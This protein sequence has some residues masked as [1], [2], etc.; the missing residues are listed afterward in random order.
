MSET[1]ITAAFVERIQ[2][3][4]FDTLPKQAVAVAKQV[5]TDTL[6]VMLAGATRAPELAAILIPYVR[7]QGGEPQA[8]VVSGGFKTS[9]PNAA[10]VNGTLANVLEYDAAWSPPNHPAS[11]TVPAILAIAEGQRLSGAEVLEAVVAAFEVQA[12]VRLAGT[13]LSGRFHKPGTTGMFG[14]AAGA[15]KAFKLDPKQMAMALGLAGSK[16]GSLGSNSGTMTK[17]SHAG[18]SARMGV[19][20]ALLARMGWTASADVF[21]PKGYFDTFMKESRPEL[22]LKGFGS[23]FWM[24]KPGVGFKAYP[25]IYLI[26]RAIDAALALKREHAFKPDQIA[27]VE[28]VQP[29]LSS[30]DRATPRDGLDAKHSTQ[31]ST[32]IA[33]L[34]GAVTIDSYSAERMQAADVKALLPKVQYKADKSIAATLEDMHATVIVTLKDGKKLS[35]RQ[36]QLAGW[37]GNPL[38]PEQQRAKFLSCAQPLLEQSD[39]Q[40]MLDL[41]DRIETLSDISAL[42]D[43]ARCDK[44]SA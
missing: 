35:K 11:P 36:D 34:D 22:L 10:F 23:P 29:P 27:S 14:A 44:R 25:C 39:A 28:I 2:V 32:L 18:H 13:G 38:T 6:A 17:P 21:G 8:S 15:A 9:M 3:I 33:L 31:Y 41:A 30:V 37:A 19:E 1:P 4:K 5:V 43:I 42:M 16:A 40:R 7:E 20:C 12:R 24:I 26:H